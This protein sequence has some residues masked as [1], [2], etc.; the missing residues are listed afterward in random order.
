MDGIVQF[1]EN[2]F[3]AKKFLVGSEPTLAD[4]MLFELCER[5]QWVTQSQ[6]FR[7]Y[8]RL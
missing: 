6:L 5:V 3:D 1:M 8:P 4:F 7:T 2:M